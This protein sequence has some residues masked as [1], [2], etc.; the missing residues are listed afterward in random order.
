MIH[1]LEG[2]DL[3]RTIRDGS[4]AYIYL[5]SLAFIFNRSVILACG[6]VAGQVRVGCMVWSILEVYN[7]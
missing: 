6:I 4:A 5:A 7:M 3:Q 2:M 1:G